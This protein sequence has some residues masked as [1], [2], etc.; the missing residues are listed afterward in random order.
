MPYLLAFLFCCVSTLCFASEEALEK[1]LDQ[2]RTTVRL[3]ALT[4]EGIQSGSGFIISKNGHIGT[5][6]HVIE[7][8][9]SI[10]VYLL[11]ESEVSVKAYPC[12]LRLEHEELDLAIIQISEPNVDLPSPLKLSEKKASLLTDVIAIGFPVALDV[13]IPRLANDPMTELLGKREAENFKPNFTKGTISK[14]GTW[15]VHDA[16]IAS[17]N[18]GGPLVSLKT[19]EVIG[20]NTATTAQEAESTK[21]Y[22]ALPIEPLQEMLIYL[23]FMESSI[24]VLEEEVALG[25][26]E[27]MPILADSILDGHT[28]AKYTAEQAVE[29]YEKSAAK[30]DAYA[31]RRL[32]DLYREG[33]H[34]KKDINQAIMY[35]LY[36]GDA[37][38]FTS[39]AEIYYRGTEGE[40]KNEKKA[41]EYAQQAAEGE[42]PEGEYYYALFTLEG[43]GTTAN[44]AKAAKILQK[45]VKR[46]H[47]EQ[48]QVPSKIILLQAKSML[49][50][51]D[52]MCTQ[53][54]VIYAKLIFNQPQDPLWAEACHL[55]GD[56]HHLPVHALEETEKA[57]T[58]YEFAAQALHEP[59]LIQLGDIYL[60]GQGV[61][62]N[63]A[64]AIPLFKAALKIEDKTITHWKLFYAYGKNGQMD[65]A[66]QPCINAAERGLAEAQ[67]ILGCLYLD[68]KY[69]E[70]SDKKARYWLEKAAE[71]E[72]ERIANM[73]KEAL[74]EAGF[75]K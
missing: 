45:A 75:I 17:G 24:S 53:M 70:Q 16:K 35:Y 60:E 1:I 55:L 20:V 44:P 64:L 30:G 31:K 62:K 12:H 73:A 5:C 9:Q 43:I 52:D 72:N 40:R 28:G 29:L 2:Q 21:F 41:Y 18:S 23:Q 32:A 3:F 48:R 57:I 33:K 47:A 71:S 46:Y 59:S 4:P 42:D 36:S 39:L 6:Q 65:L 68:G 51:H 69:I 7:D 49:V 15:L 50:P 34:L 14:I 58:Y 74:R 19:G 37:S 66:I 10:Y 27:Y 38:S 25:N 56:L 54:A 26:T 13:L 8:A 61:E 22:Y 11:G 67:H 63:P